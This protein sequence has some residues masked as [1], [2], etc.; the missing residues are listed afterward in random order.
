MNCEQCIH[1]E[2]CLKEAQELKQLFD[3]SFWGEKHC[4]DFKS[5]AS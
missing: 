1:F 5:R 4:K 2:K 3:P